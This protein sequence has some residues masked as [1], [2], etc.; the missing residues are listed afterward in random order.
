MERVKSIV[1][2]KIVIY[3]KDNK[4]L[5]LKRSMTSNG[6]WNRDLPGW[7]ILLNESPLE[8]LER[9]ITEETWLKNITWICPIHTFAKT[10]TDWV[11]IFFVGYTWVKDDMWEVILSDEHDE[12][13]WIDPKDVE[14]YKLQ[15]YRM[16]TV[17]KSV[18]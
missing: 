4:I 15:E 13:L 8:C 11:H 12:Y 16:E 10:Y 9:E 17:K 6:P 3:N 14:S 18:K 7:G 5:I 2:Q 1:G